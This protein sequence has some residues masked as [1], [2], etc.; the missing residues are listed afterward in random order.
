MIKKVIGILSIVALIITGIYT[1]RPSNSS[2]QIF[3]GGQE[4][5]LKY[6]LKGGYIEYDGDKHSLKS[7]KNNVIVDIAIGDIDSDGKDNILV[8]EGRKNSRFADRLIIYD[9]S[10]TSN[11]LHVSKRYENNMGAI[12]PWKIELCEIDADNNPEIFIIVNKTTQES[13]ELQNRPF[14]FNF[15]EDKLV[16][17]WT[18]SKLRAPFS[19]A[20]FGDLNGNGSDEFIVVEEIGTGE[21][22]ISAY[23]WFGFGFI[24]QGESHIYDRVDS[25]SIEKS[26]GNVFIKARVKDRNM[27]K[28]VVLEPSSEKTENDI[29]LLKER[30]N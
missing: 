9:V 2:L 26:D 24:L 8:L 16:K 1:I 30:G 21:F 7:Y 14:F 12:R 27:V 19:K 11:K 10:T 25:I 23:Y 13:S 29:Y 17:K 18:G 20:S 6:S 15:K 22:I 5:T 28:S 3:L 4:Y